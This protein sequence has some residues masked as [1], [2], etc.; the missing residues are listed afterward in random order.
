MPGNLVFAPKACLQKLWCFSVLR[1]AHQE[2]NFL[3]SQLHWGMHRKQIKHHGIAIGSDSPA[4]FL[5]SF[6]H[7]CKVCQ[8]QSKACQQVEAQ[9]ATEEIFK[10]SQQVEA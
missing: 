9:C 3:N 5:L 2:I 4:L 7:F 8:V 1:E 6:L 10:V